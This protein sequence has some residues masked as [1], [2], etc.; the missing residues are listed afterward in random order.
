MMFDRLHTLTTR[1]VRTLIRALD[2]Y[3]ERWEV[4]GDEHS[5]TLRLRN[6]VERAYCEGHSIRVPR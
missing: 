2:A 1:E 4:R 6:L 5:T 3:A